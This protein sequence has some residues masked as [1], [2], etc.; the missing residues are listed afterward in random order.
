MLEPL[1][2]PRRRFSAGLVAEA[3]D[4]L[5]GLGESGASPELAA[6]ALG[7]LAGAMQVVGRWRR[8]ALAPANC[9]DDTLRVADRNTGRQS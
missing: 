3:V 8:Q 5:K 9:A 1:A 4:A 6:R 7:N 2:N